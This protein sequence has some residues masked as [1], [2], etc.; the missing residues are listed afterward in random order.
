M[1]RKKGMILALALSAFFAPAVATGAQ[2]IETAQ[3]GIGTPEDEIVVYRI[4]LD[5]D[6]NSYDW[7]TGAPPEKM[8]GGFTSPSTVA[9]FLGFAPGDKLRPDELAERCSA[10]R[11]RLLRSGFFFGAS[12]DLI[13]PQAHPERRTVLIALREGFVW[14]FGGG[15]LF[16][17][18]GQA[19]AGGERKSWMAVAGYNYDALSWRDELFFG[20]PLVLGAEARFSHNLGDGFVDGLSYSGALELGWRFHPDLLVSA[21]AEAAWHDYRGGSAIGAFAGAEDG[22]YATA[23]AGFRWD[24]WR[25]GESA[26]LR[27]IADNRA[28]L[29]FATARPTMADTAPL[30][31]VWGKNSAAFGIGAFVAA[32]QVAYGHAFAAGSPVDYA[33]LWDLWSTQDIG[34]RSGWRHLDLM[35]DSFALGKLELRYLVAKIPFSPIIALSIEPFAFVDAALASLS[36]S[37]AGGGYEFF[38][39]LGGGLRLGLDNPVFAYFTFAYGLNRRGEARFTMAGGAGF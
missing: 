8:T 5:I 25:S 26:S 27:L 16:A 18:V 4:R 3:T 9:S 36:G 24:S 10:A 7:T 14:R 39:A 15:N 2:E 20:L 11:D 38:D 21:T 34:V 37:A 35:T 22:L 12:V 30:P 32:A 1:V 6:G 13:P 17:M 28:A 33:F 31:L 19:N 29:A 23:G